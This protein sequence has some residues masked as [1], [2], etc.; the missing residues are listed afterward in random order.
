M[1]RQRLSNALNYLASEKAGARARFVSPLLRVLGVACC[2]VLTG[3]HA[4]TAVSAG[5]AKAEACSTCHGPLGL[6]QLPNAPHLA[7]QPE[8]YVTEQLKAYRSGK[9]SNEIMN[10]IAKPLTDEDIGQLAAFYASLVI[11]VKP[12]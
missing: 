9:R 1:Q 3:A 7:G 5:K 4:Q 11:V 6:S 8:I 12:P 2:A 10:V